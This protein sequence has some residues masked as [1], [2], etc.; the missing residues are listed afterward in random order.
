M[1]SD[2]GIHV[3]MVATPQDPTRYHPPDETHPCGQ[4]G[5]TMWWTG[6]PNLSAPIR[7]RFFRCPNCGVQKIDVPD[8]PQNGWG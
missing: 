5:A 2:W 7:H 3:F 1:P 6:L 8:E 4:C